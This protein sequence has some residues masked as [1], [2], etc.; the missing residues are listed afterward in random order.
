MISPIKFTKDEEEALDLHPLCT[1][2]PEMNDEE[3]DSLVQSMREQGFLATDPIVVFDVT[4]QRTGQYQIL[5]GRNRALAA[6]DAGVQPCYVEYIGDD[7]KSFVLSRNMDRRHLSSGQKA[8]VASKIATMK[9][10]QNQFDEEAITREEAAKALQTSV[11]AIQRYR[12]V[13]K[14]N[15]ELAEQVAIGAVTLNEAERT[16]KR[17]GDGPGDAPPSEYEKGAITGEIKEQAHNT[18]TSESLDPRIGTYGPGPSSEANGDTVEQ[19]WNMVGDV[20]TPITYR[21]DGDANFYTI[22]SGNYWIARVQLNGEYTVTQQ[23][24]I[25]AGIVTALGLPQS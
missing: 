17:E 21:A 13:E 1:V 2:F 23:E 20:A 16:I 5:D 19:P 24:E 6:A 11:K 25:M 3:Y 12:F 10:G 18:F 4:E 8:A 14:H 15:P 22:S 9:F 7:P